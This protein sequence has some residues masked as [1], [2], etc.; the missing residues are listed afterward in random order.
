VTPNAK[1]LEEIEAEIEMTLGVDW[2]K[3][4]DA[5]VAFLTANTERVVRMIRD[6]Q[7]LGGAAIE[8]GTE[9]PYPDYVAE[10]IA[11]DDD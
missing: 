1:T 2:R 5:R 7:T 4:G 3:L 10:G 8:S 11:V 6:R 9:E